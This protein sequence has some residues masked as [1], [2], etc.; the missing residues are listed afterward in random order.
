MPDASLAFTR[1]SDMKEHFFQ[2]TC[3]AIGFTCFG[4]RSGEQA[5]SAT[6][7]DEL[8]RNVLDKCQEMA[9]HEHRRTGCRTL[10]DASL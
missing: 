1:L 5:A 4:E 8:L 2:R 7:D 10:D 3:D 6:K 9:A